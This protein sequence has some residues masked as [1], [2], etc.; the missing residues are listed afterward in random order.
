MLTRN[1]TLRFAA[2]IL[3]I[4]A[5]ALAQRT[6]ENATTRAED[7]FGTSVGGEQIGIYNPNYVRGFSAAEAGNIRLEDLYFDQQANFT[8]RLI[9]GLK[10]RVGLSAQSYPFP[11]PTGIADYGLRKPSDKPLLSIGGRVGPFG[12][13]AI[14]LDAQL[15][16]TARL[17]VGA[18]IGVIADRTHTG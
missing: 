4:P 6:E 7:A 1:R 12:T 3:A 5:P 17:S 14:E 13:T 16:V 8:E 2:A 15:P 18:G 11:A 9:G 10:M